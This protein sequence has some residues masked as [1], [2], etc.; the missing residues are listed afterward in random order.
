MYDNINSSFK[1]IIENYIEPM[2]SDE[3]KVQEIT[4]AE[5]NTGIFVFEFEP[6]ASEI[7]IEARFVGNSNKNEDTDEEYLPQLIGPYK[8]V[9]GK[10]PIEE[11]SGLM[12]F[13]PLKRHSKWHGNYID[14]T[15]HMKYMKGLGWEL[16]YSSNGPKGKN[17]YLRFIRFLDSNFNNIG[18]HK[19]R[20]PATKFSI[21]TGIKENGYFQTYPTNSI[22]D[23]GE[24]AHIKVW[25]RPTPK[26]TNLADPSKWDIPDFK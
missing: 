22:N 6:A 11:D 16:I 23:T 10:P 5:D 17:G 1:D 24:T 7:Y 3:W 13:P 2:N 4:I 20:Q 14:L 12:Y 8:W 25:Y 18:A 9:F 26:A 21:C 15:F 19:G